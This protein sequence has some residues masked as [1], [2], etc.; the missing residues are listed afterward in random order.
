MSSNTTDAAAWP[1]PFAGFGMHSNKWCIDNFTVE[2]LSAR[3][4]TLDRTQQMME[5][6]R[7]KTSPQQ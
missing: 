3:M 7:W 5:F 2:G 1:I 6:E 4:A